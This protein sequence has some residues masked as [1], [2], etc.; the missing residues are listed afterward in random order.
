MTFSVIMVTASESTS[1]VT[2]M[3]IVVMA[4]MSCTKNAISGASAII[5]HNVL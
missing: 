5:I 3:I 4:V 1:Y 2:S